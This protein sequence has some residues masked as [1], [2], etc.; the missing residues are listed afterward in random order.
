MSNFDA[1]KNWTDSTPGEKSAIPKFRIS[2]EY[3]ESKNTFFVE[4]AKSLPPPKP[5]KKLTE[6]E[7]LAMQPASTQRLMKMT[8][9]EHA[10]FHATPIDP[11]KAIA[12]KEAYDE[13]QK[14]KEIGD[15]AAYNA[16]AK[17]L[18]GQR[19]LSPEEITNYESFRRASKNTQFQFE[20]GHGN[21]KSTS[22]SSVTEERR[23]KGIDAFVYSPPVPADEVDPA[24]IIGL[25]EITSEL[26]IKQEE[27]PESSFLRGLFQWF[28]NSR[29]KHHEIRKD[30]VIGRKID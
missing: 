23:E 20:P 4:L 13:M 3:S 21:L 8:D 29:P 14:A 17:R 30:G 16:A 9:E 7:I 12:N 28:T 2:E 19:D 27:K 18:I 11:N 25:K 15:E 5:R 24:K 26:P 6:E 1:L 10:E 22:H